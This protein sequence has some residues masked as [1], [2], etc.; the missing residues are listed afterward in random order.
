MAEAAKHVHWSQPVSAPAAEVMAQEGDATLLPT[1]WAK[2]VSATSQTISSGLY[3]AS[4]VSDSLLS[5]ARFGSEATLSTV[6]NTL[7]SVLSTLHSKPPEIVVHGPPDAHAEETG[8]ADKAAQ[9]PSASPPA[10]ATPTSTVASLVTGVT[11]IVDAASDAGV[12]TVNTVFSF[13][14]LLTF[15]TFHIASTSMKLSFKAASET[16]NIFNSLF[17]STETSRALTH[18]VHLVHQE[19]LLHDPAFASRG[20]FG[21]AIGAVTLTGGI[22]K[23]LAAYA[24]LQIMTHERTLESRKVARLI[25]Q[26]LEPANVDPNS[27]T[28]TARK[29][30][31]WVAGGIAA[32]VGIHAIDPA[33][34]P[35]LPPGAVP[36]STEKK[37]PRYQWQRAFRSEQEFIKAMERL[38]IRNES[39]SASK[40]NVNTKRLSLGRLSMKPSPLTVRNQSSSDEEA[41]LHSA[42][43]LAE[44]SVG[45]DSDMF[46]DA[47]SFIGSAMDAEDVHDNWAESMNKKGDHHLSMHSMS[48][49]A[50][51]EKSL[52]LPV[53]SDVVDEY[54][55]K[56]T[57][58][59]WFFDYVKS[60]IPPGPTEMYNSTSM[61]GSFDPP[62]I[63]DEFEN[64]SLEGDHS[65][66]EYS[67]GVSTLFD[68]VTLSKKQ[69]DGTIRRTHR[70]NINNMNELDDL[71]VLNHSAF[72][73]RRN[74][75][76]SDMFLNDNASSV[77]SFASSKMSLGMGRHFPMINL[78]DN[79]ARYCRYATA[80][81]GSE[82]MT[83]FDVGNIRKL[84]GV[85]DPSVPMN[86][87]AFATHVNIPVLDIVHSSFMDESVPISDPVDGATPKPDT[88]EGSIQPVVHYVSIDREAGV[89]VVTLRGTLS[90]SDL[91]I[92]LKF[93]YAEYKGHRVHAGMLHTA[94]R[95]WK[96][97]SCLFL[98]VENAL[99]ENPSFGLVLV[100]HSLGGG[101]ATL[102][103]LEWSTL[104][105][106][107]NPPTPYST[108]P[109]SGLP[110]FRPMHVYSFGTPCV[111]DH[112]CSTSLKGLATTLIH[113]DDM[114][115]TMSVGLIRD[116]KTVTF[117]LL[118]PINR[119]LSE[120]IMARTL[121]LQATQRTASSEEQDF[122]FNVISQLR[123]SMQN[124]RLYPSGTVYWVSHQ[125]GVRGDGSVSSQ[126]ILR[127]CEEVKE[128][129]HEPVFSAKMMSD[130]IP[131]NYEDCMEAL[132]AAIAIRKEE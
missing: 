83:V 6:K 69:K 73:P 47:R 63:L 42:K 89:V 48:S 50:L 56:P 77:V 80:S 44:D 12:S 35:P 131:K 92:D 20:I 53:D 97:D 23:A 87:V 72:D 70:I 118:D 10:Q 46:E 90:L 76:A 45:G 121:A 126:V 1:T 94:R 39:L 30:V 81:Y 115:P 32:G 33:V 7:I 41:G 102:L 84:K 15:G 116:L 68:K 96:R 5:M 129:C 14:E 107:S 58:S 114:I 74:S 22:T 101:V 82:F 24:C 119:G 106:M 36:A 78:V 2:G 17:G 59:N 27:L 37:S 128:I 61:P 95:L 117:H 88:E 60:W 4:S 127:R 98:A 25:E 132:L 9:P 40:T 104:S 122:F 99:Q 75:M 71:S 11:G 65:I 29:A 112:A 31:G 43:S 52:V 38:N 28:A 130:H 8:G 93:D 54:A 3:S 51:D 108:S 109:S 34:A 91:L 111:V 120:K 57:I 21:N 13:A 16:V 124:D 26:D 103:A 62:Q 19:I 66:M 85:N 55:V 49:S 64:Y 79:L 86:H 110:A 18:L 113:G 105:P 67:A 123:G 125:Q 100:G